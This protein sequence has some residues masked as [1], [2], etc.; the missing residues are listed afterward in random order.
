MGIIVG[1]FP[2]CGRRYLKDNCRDG[3]IVESV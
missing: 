2:G 1:G 3:I